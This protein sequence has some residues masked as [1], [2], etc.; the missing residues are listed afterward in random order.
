[1]ALALRIIGPLRVFEDG[2]GCWGSCL[3]QRWHRWGRQGAGDG[4]FGLTLRHVISGFGSCAC[5]DTKKR[6]HEASDEHTRRSSEKK[7]EKTGGR[8]HAALQNKHSHYCPIHTVE[9]ASLS[10][11]EWGS[12]PAG[13]PPY[14]GP[15]R[16]RALGVRLPPVGRRTGRC[17]GPGSSWLPLNLW[18]RTGSSRCSGWCRR[19]TSAPAPPWG[20]Q[21]WHHHC[22]QRHHQCHQQDHDNQHNH[23]H[24]TSVRASVWPGA[25]EPR[26]RRED[27]DVLHAG[28]IHFGHAQSPTGCRG[29]AGGAGGDRLKGERGEKEGE[30]DSIWSPCYEVYSEADEGISE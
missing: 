29:G 6:S 20:E 14:C 10:Y 24:Q 28:G 12:C 22:H 18:S 13:G 30:N 5:R 16:S 7:G 2:T 1:M 3:G 9:L 15:C 19:M 26:D 21:S 17:P 27:V 23:H 11:H 4:V 8:E 25:V